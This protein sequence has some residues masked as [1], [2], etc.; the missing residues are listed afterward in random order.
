MS[1]YW[2]KTADVYPDSGCDDT[3]FMAYDPVVRFSRFHMVAWG[4]EV[5]RKHLAG[6]HTPGFVTCGRCPRIWSRAR[7]S[8]GKPDPLIRTMR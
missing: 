3:F 8:C 7:A 1:S 6:E 5:A 4:C 2:M